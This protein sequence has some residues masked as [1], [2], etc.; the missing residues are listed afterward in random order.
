MRFDQSHFYCDSCR[1]E[2]DKRIEEKLERDR[3][4]HRKWYARRKAF[5]RWLSCFTCGKATKGKRRDARY[6]SNACRQ[7]AHRKVVS[8]TPEAASQ[9]QDDVAGALARPSHRAEPVDK[10]GRAA[11]RGPAL[12]APL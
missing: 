3:A 2:W 5:D 11:T 10:L 7:R 8:R 1:A 6:C 4:K 12:R 9:P